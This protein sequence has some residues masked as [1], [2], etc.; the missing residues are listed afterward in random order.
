MDEEEI[1]KI[2]RKEE[3]KER[4]QEVVETP[5]EEIREPMSKKNLLTIVFFSFV[6][7]ILAISDWHTPYKFVAGAYL[8]IIGV[9]L[10][11]DVE[12]TIKKFGTIKF[13]VLLAILLIIIGKVA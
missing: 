1:R 11:F 4:K 2:V 9:F 8:L 12:R 13:Y 6:M 10:L 5:V 7:I 3:L